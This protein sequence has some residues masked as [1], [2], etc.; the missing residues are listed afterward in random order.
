[1]SF[2]INFD[3]NVNKPQQETYVN[4]YAKSESHEVPETISDNKAN[5]SF[6]VQ[7]DTEILFSRYGAYSQLSSI[8]LQFTIELT[9]Q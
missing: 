5:V 8:L 6:T 1:I 2:D 7:Y 4:F 3:F 9:F